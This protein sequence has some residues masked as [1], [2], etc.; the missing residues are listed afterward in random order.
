MVNNAQNSGLQGVVCRLALILNIL[1]KEQK[2]TKMN[3]NNYYPQDST[4]VNIKERHE[5]QYWSKRFNVS[6]DALKA[7]VQ[8][9]GPLAGAVDQYLNGYEIYQC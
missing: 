8:E 5:L 2:D 1:R 7:V 9:V 3:F 6:E 4:R